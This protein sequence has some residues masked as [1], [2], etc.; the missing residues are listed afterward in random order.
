MMY[1]NGHS[2][3]SLQC[4]D[5]VS[6]FNFAQ[7]LSQKT[8]TVV[9][10]GK[11]THSTHVSFFSRCHPHPHPELVQWAHNITLVAEMEIIHGFKNIY[12]FSPRLITTITSY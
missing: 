8:S 11:R 10:G 2:V 9:I 12:F 7:K 6:Y 3:M 1:V 4:E 5:F